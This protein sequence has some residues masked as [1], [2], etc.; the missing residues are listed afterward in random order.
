[1]QRQDDEEEDQ[2]LE[3]TESET[4][5]RSAG[6]VETET[7]LARDPGWRARLRL[8]HDALEDGAQREPRQRAA[9]D[10]ALALIAA[11]LPLARQILWGAMTRTSPAVVFDELIAPALSDIDALRA[12]GEL[13]LADERLATSL[14]E[15][16][17]AELAPSMRT[18]MLDSLGRVLLA[19][20]EPEQHG[21]ALLMANYLIAGAGYTPL[22]LGTGVPAEALVAAVARHEPVAVVL[23]T[24]IAS[25]DGA[26]LAAQQIGE[27]LPA[28]EVFIGGPGATIS[29]NFPAQRI[30]KI[31]DLLDAL[32]GL[33]AG[34][35]HARTPYADSPLTHRELEILALASH[36]LS[37]PRIA[38]LL[39]VSESTVK[40]HFE[41]IRR[42]LGVSDR[43]SAV[44]LALRS[45]L[46][47]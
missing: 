37:T 29:A 13:S 3:L 9:F 5:D 35:A 11:D 46:L 15:L 22:M 6:G 41:H 18:S 4:D 43:A 17:L 26:R 44:A 40:T 47:K 7:A 1:M 12:V 34:A 39:S 31:G 28:V 8:V 38:E 20:V 23:S 36:G 24:T 16:L 33:P 2:G 10:L 27:L 21:I 32:A 19:T 42:K 45:G 25:L 14:T 30:A